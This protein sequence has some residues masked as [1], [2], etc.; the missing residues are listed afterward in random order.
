MPPLFR[1]VRSA[2]TSLRS[3]LRPT[4]DESRAAS[5]AA[6]GLMNL[7]FAHRAAFNQQMNEQLDDSS[8]VLDELDAKLVRLRTH[9]VNLRNQL[10]ASQG[11]TEATW[12][13]VKSGLS[14]EHSELHEGVRHARPWARST[15]TAGR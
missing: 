7:P 10:A 3:H 4:A 12:D 1:V 8:H 2:I 9:V 5:A 11:A 14:K 6:G 15:P 13:Q